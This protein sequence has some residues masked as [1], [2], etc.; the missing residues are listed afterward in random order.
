[1]PSDADYSRIHKLI[2]IERHYNDLQESFQGEVREREERIA[3]L[4]ATLRS[5]AE[6]G[7][8]V[9]GELEEL[10]QKCEQLTQQLEGQRAESEAKIERLQ[11]RIR[12]LTTEGAQTTTSKSGRGFF[13][14]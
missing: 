11:A 10:R 6:N 14:R 2:E 7:S 1:M 4:E 8:G 3:Q 12:E 5:Q 9:E 13:G